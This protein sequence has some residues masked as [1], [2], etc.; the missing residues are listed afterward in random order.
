MKSYPWVYSVENP[1]LNG[2]FCNKS[3]RESCFGF[4]QRKGVCGLSFSRVPL[5]QG[6]L[7]YD[8]EV[9][10][11]RWLM[12]LRCWVNLPPQSWHSYG[13]SPEWTRMCSVSRYWR[14]KRMPHSSQANGFSPRW[15]RMWRV[16]VP[17]WVNILPQM[18]QGK[19]R[20]SQWVFSCCRRV[21]GSL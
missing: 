19:G 12:R 11:R 7:A 16:M 8:G 4:L 15:L 21:A 5:L 13:F 6:S 14:V 9:C 20:V 10:I 18:L 17:R 2:S 1:C 3:R